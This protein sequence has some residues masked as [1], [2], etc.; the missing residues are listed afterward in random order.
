MN[1]KLKYKFTPL[2]CLV[3]SLSFLLSGCDFFSTPQYFDRVTLINKNDYFASLVSKDLNHEGVN[4]RHDGKTTTFTI[5]NDTLFNEN[6]ANLTHSATP[7]LNNVVKF[8]GYYDIET[9]TVS[10]FSIAMNTPAFDY[11]KS[12]AIAK[13]RALRVEKYLWSQNI[14][15]S[16]IYANGKLS[17]TTETNKHYDGFTTISFVRNYKYN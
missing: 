6:S 14:D 15:A 4:V 17:R 5:A 10:T 8:V 13:N 2:F 7:I 16:I 11:S 3:L 1:K 9:I 12:S